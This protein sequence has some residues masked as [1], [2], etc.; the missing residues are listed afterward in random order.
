VIHPYKR[1]APKAH[2]TA[3]LAASAHM[4]GDVEVGRDYFA[5]AVEYCMA[6]NA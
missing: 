2:Q 3:F 5:L 1:V 6:A 4:I